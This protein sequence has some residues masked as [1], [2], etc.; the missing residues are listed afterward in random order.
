MSLVSYAIFFLF[1]TCP[2]LLLL[3][4]FLVFFFPCDEA[5]VEWERLSTR[6][7]TLTPGPILSTTMLGKPRATF[8]YEMKGFLAMKNSSLL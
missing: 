4:F 5:L 6:V 1:S 7:K 8:I 3:F 2:L